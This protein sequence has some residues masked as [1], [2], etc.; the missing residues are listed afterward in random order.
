MSVKLVIY[1]P[2]KAFAGAGHSTI[3][4][5]TTVNACL[6]LELLCSAGAAF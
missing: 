6:S 5:G 1:F 2:S 4:F 3:Y